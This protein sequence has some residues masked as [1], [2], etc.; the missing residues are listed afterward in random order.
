MSLMEALEGAE[1]RTLHMASEENYMPLATC[2]EPVDISYLKPDWA[3]DPSDATACTNVGEVRHMLDRRLSPCM[4]A[5]LCEGEPPRPPLG[6]YLG[7]APQ[8][9]NSEHRSSTMGAR[10]A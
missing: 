8:G 7:G 4:L 5:E 6:F 9:K 2:E 1:E 10:W 3:V